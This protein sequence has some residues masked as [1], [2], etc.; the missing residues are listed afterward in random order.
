M[1]LIR[2]HFQKW[3]RETLK[4]LKKPVV[5]QFPKYKCTL[6]F[7]LQNIDTQTRDFRSILFGGNLLFDFISLWQAKT[8]NVTRFAHRRQLGAIAVFTFSLHLHTFVLLAC[9]FQCLCCLKSK[10][11]L[12]LFCIL[13]KVCVFMLQKQ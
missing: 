1:C 4:H 7:H 5:Y 9:L 10:W 12:F 6:A 8:E 13:K 2:Y 11:I 3:Q